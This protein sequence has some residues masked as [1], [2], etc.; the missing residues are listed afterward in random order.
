MKLFRSLGVARWAWHSITPFL[1]SP[2]VWLPFL[3]VAAFQF[4]TLILLQSFHKPAVLPFGLPLVRALGGEAATHYPAFFLALPTIFYWMDM[5]LA[6]FVS[7]LTAGVAT[8]LFARGFGEGGA[9]SAW[10]VAIRRYPTLLLLSAIVA[11]LLFGLSQLVGLVP[12]DLVLRNPLVRWGAR[13]AMLL[14]LVLAQSLLV[15]ATAW[16]VLQGHRLL[17]AIRDSVRVSLRTF[18]PTVMIV[19]VPLLL[20]FPLGYLSG[21]GDLF[22][23]KLQPDTIGALLTVRVLSEIVLGFFLIGAVTRLFLW[24]LGGA[25]R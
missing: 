25:Q 23:T 4:S 7:S 18:L 12:Q 20:L 14:L 16:I 3:V 5:F 2:T 9:G 19:G 8:E 11:A 22:V 6:V 15:Y 10:M 21:R 1:A 17:P 13:V 24:R